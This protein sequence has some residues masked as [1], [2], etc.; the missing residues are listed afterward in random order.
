MGETIRFVER[1]QQGETV[2]DEFYEKLFGKNLTTEV[3]TVDLPAEIAR[4]SLYEI[5]ATLSTADEFVRYDT[6]E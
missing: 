2:M 6:E 4:M 1:T 5:A 3:P